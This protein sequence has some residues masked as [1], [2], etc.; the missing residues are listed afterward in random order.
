LKQHLRALGVPEGRLEQFCYAAHLDY[1]YDYAAD[2]INSYREAY[3]KGLIDE[4]EYL[5]RLQQVGLRPERAQGLLARDRLRRKIEEKE[6]P[7]KESRGMYASRAMALFREGFITEQKL[8]EHLRVL[9]VS[10]GLH[11]LYIYAAMLDYKLDYA[12]D[13][14]RLIRESYRNRALTAEEYRENMRWL[15]LREDRI[16]I[17]LELDTLRMKEEE[18][19]ESAAEH[20]REKIRSLMR[21]FRDGFLTE[22]QFRA[23][24]RWMG[25]TE[26]EINDIVVTA[27]LQWQHEHMR[28]RVDALKAAYRAGLIDEEAL[29]T[30][31]ANMGLAPPN[32]DTILMEETARKYGKSRK[33]R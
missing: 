9:G 16:D 7:E 5:S 14:M 17:L 21:M 25:L 3:R 20:H 32:I 24:L 33:G 2:L 18:A 26:E 22:D 15:G 12:R 8:R 1:Q 6:E 19:G 13:F 31:L 23:N 4:S 27:T 11:D 30:E 28:E 29:R 10:D